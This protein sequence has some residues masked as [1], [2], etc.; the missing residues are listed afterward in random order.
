MLNVLNDHF[1]SLDDATI[2]DL[3]IFRDEK[4]KQKYETL[5]MYAF[6][7]L[8][9]AEYHLGNVKTLIAN[10]QKALDNTNPLT[11]ELNGKIKFSSSFKFT[12]EANEYIYELSAF[13]EALK[14]SLDILAEV[15]SFYLPGV[16][17][18]YSI[19]PLLK[20]VDKGRKNL[21]LDV[22][23]QNLDW[24]KALRDYR[25]HL[26]HRLMLT[27]NSGYE[28]QLIGDKT[29]KVN[30][31]VVVPIKTP[32]F[33]L[34]TRLSQMEEM[35]DSD[36]IDRFPGLSFGS[37]TGKYIDADGIEHI[38]Q[39]GLHATPNKGYKRI[40]DFMDEHL[41][42]YISF[43]EQMISTF[44]RLEFQFIQNKSG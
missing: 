14:S 44:E 11:L 10:D 16:Q 41:K 38:I 8:K 42:A 1:S 40:E 4:D 5:L 29:A 43:S 37:S 15:C 6:R 27:A 35:M 30:Y 3:S 9:A 22:I 13:L 17:T 31:P 26:V 24:L 23:E 39:F 33:I 20:L 19:S 36:E 2:S 18:N 25:H 12:K 28:T 32:S 21:I 34:D 7:K